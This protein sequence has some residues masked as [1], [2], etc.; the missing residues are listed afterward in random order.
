MSSSLKWHAKCSF[1]QAFIKIH[2]WWIEIW[3]SFSCCCWDCRYSS[4]C[5]RE[6]FIAHWL[7]GKSF[8]LFPYT[9]LDISALFS[10]QSPE[11][12]QDNI[13]P[14]TYVAS[15]WAHYRLY[16]CLPSSSLNHLVGYD[17]ISN[18]FGIQWCLVQNPLRTCWLLVW[19]DTL[20]LQQAQCFRTG[21]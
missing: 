19:G 10:H 13:I 8:H 2:R 1:P 14:F 6:L 20:A 18:F 5:L 4:W 17:G 16:L 21:L 7:V 11:S 9:V 12:N 15:L 3:F